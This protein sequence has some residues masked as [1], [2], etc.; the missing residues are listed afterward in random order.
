MDNP[1]VLENDEGIRPAG[2]PDVCFYCRQKV[3]EPHGPACVMV[4]KR[5]MLRVEGLGGFVG[6]WEYEV[7]FSWDAEMC[8]FQW[9]ES[10]MCQGNLDPADVAWKG[11]AEA[12]IAAARAYGRGRGRDACLCGFY[13]ITVDRVTVAG[14]YVRAME[15]KSA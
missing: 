9:M 4:H 8:V 3:G 5:V 13:T 6:E 12:A 1:R 14:P 10:S 2:P 11:D 15:E 7:P